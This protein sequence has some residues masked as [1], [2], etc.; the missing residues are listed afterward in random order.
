MSSTISVA[1]LLVLLGSAGAAPEASRPAT[2]VSRAAEALP[3]AVLAYPAAGT[4]PSLQFLLSPPRWSP[5][6]LAAWGGPWANIPGGLY[7]HRYITW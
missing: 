5:Q 7:D 4:D 3:E 1:A 2:E 6:A